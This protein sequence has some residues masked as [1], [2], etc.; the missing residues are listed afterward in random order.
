MQDALIKPH[1]PLLGS[2]VDN[3]GRKEVLRAVRIAGWVLI[4]L[5]FAGLLWWSARLTS[6][7][8]MSWDYG[9]YYQAWWAIAHG[10][11]NPLT[12]VV[13]GG[14]PFWQSDGEF[15]VWLLAPL[16]WILPAHKLGF[17]WLQD[18]AYTGIATVCYR[19]IGE[20]LPGEPGHVSRRNVVAAAGWLVVAFL[21]V[22]NPWTYWSASFAVQIEPFA[23]LFAMLAVRAL[24]QRR[25]TVWLWCLLTALCGSA[26]VIY[27]IGVGLTGIGTELWRWYSTR[28]RRASTQRRLSGTALTSVAICG[29][30]LLWLVVLGAIH[31]TRS[32]SEPTSTIHQGLAYLLGSH[33]T[34]GLALVN[35]AGSAVAHPA[36][37]VSVLASHA[38]NLWANTAAA[39]LVG[40]VSA[41][42]FFLSAPTLL[43]NSLLHN[44]DF[45][46]P[47][48]SNLI[49]YPALAVG[50]GLVVATVIRRHPRLGLA[51]TVLVIAN[52]AAWFAIWVPKAGSQY[53]RIAPMA[54]RSLR[55]AAKQIPA[56]DE[57]I[58]SQG[59]VGTFAARNHIYAF[60]SP[61]RSL[62]GPEVFPVNADEVWFVLSADQ[63]IEGPST[64][65]TDEAIGSV[66]ALPGASL[67]SHTDG[68]WIFKW[69]PSTKAESVSLGGTTAAVPA[70]TTGGAS[71]RL[72]AESGS[73]GLV[74][75]STPGYLVSG[76]IW[77]LR[78][79]HYSA[80]ISLQSTKP[81]NVEIWN[82]AA[83]AVTLCSDGVR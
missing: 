52:A 12:S 47:G 18:F 34:G 55:L 56:H 74:A 65:E 81:A 4:A 21:L 38:R 8:S 80:D 23:V 37:V 22:L 77:R 54:A 28:D 72:Q 63:G 9:T 67:V 43:E 24:T 6:R 50:A 82:D 2:V 29:G 7:A 14:F 19:W 83:H 59:F 60:G 25:R 39:G 66:A 5:Q 79:G 76:D 78:R 68:I 16:Y 61:R 17:W 53:V 30:A 13:P 33:S 71:S 1:G 69:R 11:L 32:I 10:H 51:L 36:T 58:A 35:A 20:L 46:Y 26:A 62:P 73:L 57:V 48:F 44:Q 64:A 41:P 70:W 75:N 40:L 42:G 45:S 3:L 15:I 27:V 31:A 49:V